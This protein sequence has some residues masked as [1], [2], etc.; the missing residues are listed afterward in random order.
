VAINL[1]QIGVEEKR[2]KFNKYKKSVLLSADRDNPSFRNCSLT[3]KFI[4]FFNL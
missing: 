3:P 1:Q 2:K 4:V